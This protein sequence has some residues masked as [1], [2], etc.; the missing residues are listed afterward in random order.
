MVKCKEWEQYNGNEIQKKTH[1]AAVA[2]ILGQNPPVHVAS[3]TASLRI[4][5]TIIKETPSGNVPVNSATPV[6][7][8]STASH[9]ISRSRSHTLQHQD[10]ESIFHNWLPRMLPPVPITAL[11]ATTS[12]VLDSGTTTINQVNPL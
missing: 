1:T 12:H 10:S 5:I 3:A 11:D 4:L 6:S 2:T 7:P 9:F 8:L